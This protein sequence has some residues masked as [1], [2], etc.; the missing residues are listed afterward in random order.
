MAAEYGVH[1]STKPIIIFI[2]TLC[3]CIM[4]LFCRVISG[5]NAL[6]VF[7]CPMLR[8]CSK[9][10]SRLRRR[11]AIFWLKFSKQIP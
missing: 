8:Y 3:I 10:S 1:V 6:A 11:H 4:F 5:D 9:N 7:I 2:Q